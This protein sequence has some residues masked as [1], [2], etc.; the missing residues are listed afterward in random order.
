MKAEETILKIYNDGDQIHTTLCWPSEWCV[1]ECSLDASSSLRDMLNELRE[2]CTGEVTA[3]YIPAHLCSQETPDSFHCGGIELFKHIRLTLDDQFEYLAKLP[4]LIGLNGILEKYLRKATDNTLLLSPGC[5]T[6]YLPSPVNRWKQALN[7]I[8]RMAIKDLRESVKP[9]VISTG[10]DESKEKHLLRNQ[11]G[12]F[13]FLKE[14]G[15]LSDNDPV[16]KEKRAA[17]ED[18]LWL[19]KM[20]FLYPQYRTD[21]QSLSKTDL[22]KKCRDKKF[23]LIDDQ[24]RQG[25]GYGLAAGLL[26]SK[27]QEGSET[28][29]A[30][31]LEQIN[32][33]DSG[34]IVLDGRGVSLRCINSKNSAEEYFKQI[35]K[36]FDLW[37]EEG[38]PFNIDNRK[39]TD[40]KIE[41]E[42]FSNHIILL[43]LRLNNDDENKSPEVTS[44]MELL[45]TI[46]EYCPYLPV[47]IMTGSEKA[48]G[49]HAAQAAGVDGFWIKAESS[50]KD[51]Q[52]KIEKACE[53]L[54]QLIPLWKKV[55]MVKRK[56]NINVY[57]YV[58]GDKNKEPKRECGNLD[59]DN[60]TKVNLLLAES[61]QL[62]KLAM[63][64]SQ[65][66]KLLLRTVVVNMYLIQEIRFSNV[67]AIYHYAHNQANVN[68]LIAPE[69]PKKEES[70]TKDKK[71]IRK[72]KESE[73]QNF[74]SKSIADLGFSTKNQELKKLRN[75]LVHN[76]RNSSNKIEKI[77]KKTI[78]SFHFTLNELLTNSC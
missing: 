38:D 52:E 65:N 49:A 13:K 69:K 58:V 9:Y 33:S 18:E 77:E 59:E 3:L 41:N 27:H 28:H 14:F 64:A 12:V 5:R 74:V 15:G 50:G 10:D 21:C 30:N 40:K 29:L 31:V 55:E 68:G 17:I 78:E 32:S 62:L 7:G 19:K 34:D 16:V 67:D 57:T 35:G 48:T 45:K 36:E 22:H 47:I 63:S 76:K 66:E 51:L 72:K 2:E 54:I 20:C 24:F 6:I 42:N 61:L 26:I 70:E 46:R 53:K 44:G 56:N 75:S 71:K 39:G 37:Q 25:W 23:I 60:R 11:A 73:R 8:E 1:K 43:D 4:V